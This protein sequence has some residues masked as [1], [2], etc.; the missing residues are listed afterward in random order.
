MQ[1]P[2]E[3]GSAGVFIGIGVKKHPDRVTG[4][5]SGVADAQGGGVRRQR[6]LNNL[7]SLHSA[8]FQRPERFPK[9]LCRC[10][11]FRVYLAVDQQSLANGGY[12]CFRFKRLGNQIG[13]FWPLARK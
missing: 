10:R 9:K 1:P 7:S 11:I 5:F 2:A 3:I 6:G 8:N 12:Y 4:V 13:R